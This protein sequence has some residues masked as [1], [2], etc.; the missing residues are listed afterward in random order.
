LKKLLALVVI[1]T[2]SE[3]ALAGDVSFPKTKLA[4]AKGQQT[5]ADLIFRES[6]K[7]LVVRRSDTTVAEV[8]YAEI[9]KLSY[10][11]SK[12]HRITSGAIVMVASI[13]AGAIVMLTKS[14][15]HWFT[16]DYHE[17]AAAKSLVLRL[18][19]S[20]Y[21]KVLETAKAQT[22]KDVIFLKDAKLD[23]DKKKAGSTTAN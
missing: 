20:E 2:V 21:K 22:G 3:L 15:S 11:Y 17:G 18:D 13:G 12:H 23:K 16:V 9:D 7:S 14:K 1:L 4:D 19:K 10:D 5:H 8:P 6:T